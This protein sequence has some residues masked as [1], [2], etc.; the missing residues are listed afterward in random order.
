[1]DYGQ[2]TQFGFGTWVPI[3]PAPD[4][5]LR[6]QAVALKLTGYY[7][8]ED[9]DIDREA[10]AAGK[11]HFCG[12]NTGNQPEDQLY[13]ETVCVTDGTLTGAV[14]N[15][16]P[17]EIQQ[18]VVGNPALAMPDNIA[19]Q[20]RLGNWVIHEDADTGYQG[21]HNDDLWDCLPDGPDDDL[22]SD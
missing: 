7:R 11:V 1:T 10:E 13:G 17:P 2:G 18:L 19:Y 4:P 5:D 3:P 16:A 15:S 20:P 9:I 12:N 6:A 8:P 14:A 21:P 22:L